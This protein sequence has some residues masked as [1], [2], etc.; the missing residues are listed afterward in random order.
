MSALMVRGDFIL[1]LPAEEW[2]WHYAQ[3]TG[4]L[5]R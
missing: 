1:S 5:I 3:K 4:I 2:I